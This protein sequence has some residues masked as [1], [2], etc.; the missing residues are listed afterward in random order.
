MSPHDHWRHL[1]AVPD[2]DDTEPPFT[3]VELAK[4]QHFD[5]SLMLL[6]R[7]LGQYPRQDVGTLAP[8]GH[9]NEFT[10]V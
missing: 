4:A 9:P 1:H 6:A 5:D 7:A 2:L 3:G 10:E 8:R